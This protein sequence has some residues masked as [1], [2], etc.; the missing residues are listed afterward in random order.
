MK[1]GALT[2][3]PSSVIRRRSAGRG[4]PRARSAH[5]DVTAPIPPRGAAQPLLVL[6]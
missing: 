4:V 3:H 5:A 1:A 2:E 6:T